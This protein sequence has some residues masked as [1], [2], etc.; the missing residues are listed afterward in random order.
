MFHTCSVPIVLAY[1]SAG[2]IIAS[3]SYILF[4]C[5]MGTPFKNSLT[6]Q[7]REL[8]KKS[9][10]RRGTVFGVSFAVAIVILVLCRPFRACASAAAECKNASVTSA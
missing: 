6:P 4:T 10:S 3:V 8:K 5:N 9:S 1:L 7:Q 2:Y